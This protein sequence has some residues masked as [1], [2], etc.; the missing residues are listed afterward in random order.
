MVI[1]SMLDDQDRQVVIGA[2]SGRYEVTHVSETLRNIFRNRVP[3]ES[4][5]HESPIA[6]FGK[7][8][9]ND[10]HVRDTLF[11][12][13]HRRNNGNNRLEYGENGNARNEVRPNCFSYK[14]S[15]YGD[16]TRV[17]VT[18]ELAPA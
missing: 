1:Q 8:N 2:P 16:S 7:T 17:I 15:T 12:G 6:Q 18:L 5:Y 11:R 10:L 13:R 4:T 3:T 14:T 9:N